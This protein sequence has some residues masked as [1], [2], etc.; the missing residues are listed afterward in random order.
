MENRKLIVASPPPSR[1]SSS[2]IKHGGKSSEKRKAIFSKNQPS[3]KRLKDNSH[4]NGPIF[5]ASTA[6]PDELFPPFKKEDHV[7]I[8]DISS[9]NTRPPSPVKTPPSSNKAIKNTSD[10][11][12]VSP[13]SDD[14]DVSP[15]SIDNL[16]LTNDA[17]MLTND[18]P[19]LPYEYPQLPS[20]PESSW[21]KKSNKRPRIAK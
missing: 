20:S 3:Q 10:D 13:L 11:V 1:T 5:D 15:L 9:P 8:G 19:M 4:P 16:L 6:K 7:S 21:N 2:I 14:V 17:P 18:V 12:D